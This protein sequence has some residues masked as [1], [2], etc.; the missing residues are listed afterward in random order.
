[1]QVEPVFRK[2]APRL[3]LSS[4]VSAELTQGARGDP[5]RRLV[6]TLTR[7]L[8]RT[9]RLV[10]PT[11]ADWTH[12]ATIQSMVWDKLPSM[13]TKP[14]LLDLL[15]AQGARNIGAC[16]VTANTKDFRT[17]HDWVPIEILSMDDLAD[18]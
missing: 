1:M 17:I 13:R 5:G 11:H 15:I 12:A 16:I 10:T 3:Y 2:I 14:I 6:A 18:L 8:E 9:G 7:S 4:V